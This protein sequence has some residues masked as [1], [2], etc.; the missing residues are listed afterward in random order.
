VPKKYIVQ[1]GENAA[2]IAWGHGFADYKKVWRSNTALADRGR[3]PYTLT[4][5]DALEVP[6]LIPR[7]VDVG[8]D[9][10][11]RIVVKRPKLGLRVRLLGLEGEAWAS[12]AF[13]LEVPGMPKIEGTTDG[14]GA[15]K[16]ELPVSA[17]EAKLTV[18]GETRT[19]EL[20]HLPAMPHDEEDPISGAAARLRNLGYHVGDGAP[21]SLAFRWAVA[22]FQADHDLEVTG[23]LDDLTKGKLVEAHG[24]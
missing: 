14:D 24:I 18:R 10:R 19:L 21:D 17:Q 8:T 13:T 20:S 12:E 2:S 11:H 1:A 7:S 23:E 15:L 6:D 3:T 16:A 4:V 5:G 22:I 9:S